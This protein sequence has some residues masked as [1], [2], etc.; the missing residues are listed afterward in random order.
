MEPK[1]Q[2]SVKASMEHTYGVYPGDTML[3]ASD[4]GSETILLQSYAIHDS[5]FSV[6]AGC[7]NFP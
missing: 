2:K 6:Q 4:I 5:M 1:F 7:R 3:A